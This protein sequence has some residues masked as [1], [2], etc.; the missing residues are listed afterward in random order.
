M[1]G[2]THI[3]CNGSSLYVAPA[4]RS[5]API[6]IKRVLRF[7]DVTYLNITPARHTWPMLEAQGYVR[8]A[9][10]QF[11]ACPLLS[12][13]RANVY[14]RLATSD[15]CRGSGLTEYDN[16]LLLQHAQFGCLSLICTAE[17]E[18][19]PFVFGLRRKYGIPLAHLI[20]CHDQQ[21]FVDF[22]ASLG[23]FLCRQGIGLVILDANGRIDGLVG[24][25]FDI[26][27]KFVRGPET[28][29]LGDLPYTERPLFGF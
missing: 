5:Y 2:D 12:R 20:Y 27:P 26:Q 8:F 28:V 6:L 23:Q 14:I 9:S 7:K 4:F 10:G 18:T 29:R 13:R 25:Y 17:G 22:A 19:R 3:R 21:D 16:H 15:T 24:R 11:V 1:N